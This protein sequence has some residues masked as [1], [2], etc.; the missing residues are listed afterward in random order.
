MTLGDWVSIATI[1]QAV[2]VPVSLLLVW[3]QLRQQSR[4]TR[5]AN[6]QALVELSSPFNLQLIQDRD[7]AR[8]WMSGAKTFTEMDDV[9]KYRFRSLLT[10]WL[11]LHENVFYQ[12]QKELIDE[13]T[14]AAWQRDLEVFVRKMNLARHWSFAEVCQVEFAKHVRDIIERIER[15]DKG[16]QAPGLERAQEKDVRPAHNPSPQTDACGAA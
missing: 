14:Y 2:F 11:L 9:D 12:R 15:D 13:E 4:L 1:A 8:L 3:R 10:W 16:T 6:T 5:A 7:F